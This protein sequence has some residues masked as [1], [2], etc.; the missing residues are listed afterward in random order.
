MNGPSERSVTGMRWRWSGWSRPTSWLIPHR[1]CPRAELQPAHEPQVNMLREPR[2][3]RW[4]VARQSGVHHELVLIDQFQLRQRQRQLRASH[5]Q[6]L[7]R[8]LLEL[9]NGLPQ[10]PAYELRVPIDAVEGGRHDVL[11]CRVDCV[12][13]KTIRRVFCE[14]GV[15]VLT[16]TPKRRPKQLKLFEKEA[17]GDSFKWT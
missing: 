6:S 17:R 4:T 10:I 1:H 11:L 3:R 16:K 7:P 9:L 2:E 13:A 5:E 12:N 8:L 14:L 15:P